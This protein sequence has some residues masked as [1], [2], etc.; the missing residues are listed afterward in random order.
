MH[1]HFV[2]QAQWEKEIV[3][4]DMGTDWSLMQVVS[5]VSGRRQRPINRL[6]WLV[7][8]GEAAAAPAFSIPVE[9]PHLR[10]I[11]NNPTTAD[12]SRLI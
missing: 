12:Q 1:L 9:I 11:T 7:W 3:G 4:Q 6:R 10:R 8:S 2:R 5:Y